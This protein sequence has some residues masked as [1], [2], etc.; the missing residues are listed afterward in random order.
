MAQSRELTLFALSTLLGLSAIGPA[1][2]WCERVC[3]LAKQ[4]QCVE[5]RTSCYN[6]NNV[7]PGPARRSSF[8][9]ITYSPSSGEFGYSDH[10]ANR[11]QA[12]DRAKSE[13]GKNDCVVAT[14]FFN[15]C[16]ALA[17]SSNGSWGAEQGGNERTARSLALTRCAK[18][19]GTDCAI[20]VARC[21]Q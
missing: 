1:Q 20:K 16:G 12:E 3:S 21:S 2:A 11:A 4:G 14:W 15:H 6:D 7:T 9:A 10:T 18:E 19:G 13:C 5:Y 17:T 8:G